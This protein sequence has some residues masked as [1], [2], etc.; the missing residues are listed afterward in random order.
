M[1][2]QPRIP[3]SRCLP[4]PI[5]AA[6]ETLLSASRSKFYVCFSWDPLSQLRTILLSFLEVVTNRLQA[7]AP[8]TGSSQ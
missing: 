7:Q 8:G 4:D 3:H 2:C 1:P 6:W 5:R